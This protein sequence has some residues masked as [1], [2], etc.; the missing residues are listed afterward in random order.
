MKANE[1]CVFLFCFGLSVFAESGCRDLKDIFACTK[2]RPY[3]YCPGRTLDSLYQ[4]NP[5]IFSE[6]LDAVNLDYPG[7]GAVR[8]AAQSGHSVQASR[9]LLEYYRTGTNC[10]AFRLPAPAVSAKIYGSAESVLNWEFTIAGVQRTLELLPNGVHNWIPDRTAYDNFSG[11][12]IRHGELM[13]RVLKGWQATGN[14]RYAEG[15]DRLITDWILFD[16][17]EGDLRTPEQINTELSRGCRLEGSWPRLFYGFQQAP[18]FSEATRFLMLRSILTQTRDSYRNPGDSRYVNI[19]A[20][21]HMGILSTAAYFP[22]FR[23][24][25]VWAQSA[26]KAIAGLHRSGIFADGMETE[27]AARYACNFAKQCGDFIDLAEKAGVSLDSDYLRF[28]ENQWNIHFYLMQP[29][30][31]AANFGDSYVFPL[32]EYFTADEGRLWKRFPRADWR[33]ISSNGRTGAPPAGLPSRIFPPSG[34]VVMRNGWG[35]DAQW[36]LFDAGPKGSSGHG[37]Q[38]KLNLQVANGRPILI[39][40]GKPVYDNNV[41][42]QWLT[43]FRGSAGH[44]VL[45]FDGQGQAMPESSEPAGLVDGVD[46]ALSGNTVYAVGTADLFAKLKFSE[47]SSLL[48]TPVQR[49]AAHTREMIYLQNK[50]WIVIDHVS[51]EA[52]KKVEAPWHFAADCTLAVDGT[53]VSTVDPNVGNLTIVPLGRA[54][55]NVHVVSGQ[56]KPVIQGWHR[57]DRGARINHYGGNPIPVAVYEAPSG[58]KKFAWLLYPWSVKKPDIRIESCDLDHGFELK[59]TVDGR[60][61]TVVFPLTETERTVPLAIFAA[62][63]NRTGNGGTVLTETSAGGFHLMYKTA[64]EDSRAIAQASAGGQPLREG[65]SATLTFAFAS[66]QIRD[67]ALG[68]GWGFDFGSS[69]VVC[70]ASTGV[71]RYTF[72]QH[73]YDAAKG[74]PFTGGVQA[75]TWTTAAN[76]RPDAAYYLQAGN[77]V[78]VVTTLKRINGDQYEMTVQWGGQKY[79]SSLIFAGDHT[80]DS[81]FFRSGDLSK[82]LFNTGDNYTISNVSLKMNG[83]SVRPVF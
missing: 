17:P 9:L 8:Q 38:D 40:S 7:L 24:S 2:E 49:G 39:D 34:Q 11:L 37:H 64:Q 30:G 32:E 55:W 42:A 45:L 63:E 15:F 21:V 35:A 73:R 75:G 82:K 71:P 29:N 56:T 33:Y 13:D 59:M 78:T 66:S 5:E 14:P 53:S 10:A 76:D 20:T 50:Y 62:P 65:D 36:A 26:A 16:E 61:E 1:A 69:V 83:R 43:Y 72:L 79:S 68:F 70:T 48:P 25:P 52:F 46:Y 47:T 80:I 4:S 23:E 41:G 44:N 6:F 31:E 81:V 12:L 58:P 18:E 67:S 77:R 54:D 60:L 57:S 3:Q 28:V 19:M 22:E 51:P 27:M 74:Y